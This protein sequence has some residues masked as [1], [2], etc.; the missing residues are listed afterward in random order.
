VHG[1][2]PVELA[3][4]HAVVDESHEV[5]LIGDFVHN[6]VEAEAPAV[7]WRQRRRRRQ[8]GGG[9]GG[10]GVVK[11]EAESCGGGGEFGGGRRHR[12]QVIAAASGVVARNR[13]YDIVACMGLRRGLAENWAQGGKVIWRPK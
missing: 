12:G 13:H 1:D 6:R 9:G 4:E 8:R 10:N 3:L 7:W 5:R 2:E 11:A